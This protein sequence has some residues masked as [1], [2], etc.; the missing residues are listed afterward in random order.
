MKALEDLC[1]YYDG[2]VR[3]SAKEV[4][5]FTYGDDG[6]DPI[7][8]AEGAHPINFK[9][10]WESISA[11]C[12]MQLAE[13]SGG[14]G[15]PIVHIFTH[16]RYKPHEVK[17][18][19]EEEQKMDR[20][21]TACDLNEA[22]CLCPI[23]ERHPASVYY[24][25][26]VGKLGLEEAGGANGEGLS[27]GQFRPDRHHPA[28]LTQFPGPAW[29]NSSPK[30]ALAVLDFLADMVKK[31]EQAM[32][33]VGLG[34]DG[35][36]NSA[37]EADITTQQQ[38]QQ[39]AKRQKTETEPSAQD[40]GPL[41]EEEA[42]RVIWQAN[43]ITPRML[44]RFLNECIDK[45]ERA[46]VEP[47]TT[48]GAV[49][50]QSIGEPG[51]QMTL[52]TFHFAGVAS[53]NITLGVPRVREVINA[54]PN[55][56]TP[57]VYAQLQ[58]SRDVKAARLV[59]GKIERTTL[60]DVS[61]YVREVYEPGQCYIEI[62]LD[63][64]AVEAL[65]LHLSTEMVIDAILSDKQT[66]LDKKG[67]GVRRAGHDRIHVYPSDGRKEALSYNL[68]RLML[69]LPD[70]PVAGVPGAGRAMIIDEEGTGD[71]KVVVEGESLLEIMGTEGVDGRRTVCNHVLRVFQV[72]G[73]EAA[74]KSIITEIFKVM[75]A[76]GLAIDYRHVQLLAEIMT[77]TGEVLGITRSGISR[78]TDSV[79]TLASFEH[80]A[81]HLFEAA[82]RSTQE[83]MRSV[84][85][86][87]ITGNPI[88]IGSGIFDLIDSR[89]IEPTPP[90][91]QPTPEK[92]GRRRHQQQQVAPPDQKETAATGPGR[93]RQ[94][95][96]RPDYLRSRGAGPVQGRNEWERDK[97]L[98]Y[99]TDHE[100]YAGRVEAPVSMELAA[101]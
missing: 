78:M 26:P 52:K 8:M 18:M 88:P 28:A 14:D 83:S 81:E 94:V 73:I 74:R 54:T 58:N 27:L 15:D 2:T 39:P 7:M 33:S 76:Y 50:A 1:V 32:A 40:K 96:A 60:G 31:L 90:A 99:T 22:L 56:K 85:E 34:A 61:E 17:E 80:T 19:S 87:I 5:Q 62:K 71:F 72:L 59:K 77:F 70:I 63:K 29:H 65:H 41:S 46:R 53:M 44:Q 89:D 67:Y 101:S 97:L 42:R 21:L 98:L 16:G 55:I 4:V 30:Y 79:L 100:L 57:F 37:Q 92:P 47:G 51:T 93:D 95:K 68:A 91:P 66:K 11:E 6:L 36:R 48:V 84:S 86:S 12:N 64:G 35:K 69:R 43:R 13:R 3:T 24:A 82:L 10:R 23:G 45:Y 9:E 49:A 25:L 20:Q 38:Q 75:D